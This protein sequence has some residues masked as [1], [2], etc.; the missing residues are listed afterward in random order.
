MIR[1]LSA[2]PNPA[3]RRS[4]P[5][6]RGL[7]VYPQTGGAPDTTLAAHLIGFVNRDGQGQYGVEQ[8]Y[9][10]PLAG[11]AQGRRGGKRRRTASRCPDRADRGAGQAGR[12]P[13]ADDRRRPPAR[14]RAGAAR[15]RGSRT[16]PT[17]GRRDGSLYRR[18]LRRGELSRRTTRTPT[19]PIAADDP[20]R[21]VDPSCRPSTSRLGVQDVDG[22]RG[23]AE[24]DGHAADPSTTR[25]RSWSTAA[26][27]MSTTPTQ[28]AW[29]G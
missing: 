2:G 1:D 7:R 21:F 25:A 4:R 17:F 20:G 24:P 3:A 12:G 5:S 8:Y 23:P 22:G 6:T 15:P 29:A 18:G 11:A 10:D 16:A 13:P 9:K 28:G 14:D 27:A 19:R 26:R